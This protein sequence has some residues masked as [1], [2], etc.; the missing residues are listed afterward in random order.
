[1]RTSVELCGLGFQIGHTVLK[2]GRAIAKIDG[3]IPIAATRHRNSRGEH[4]EAPA[5]IVVRPAVFEALKVC[6]AHYS[7]IALMRALNDD[8]VAGVKVFSGMNKS[9]DRR[10]NNEGADLDCMGDLGVNPIAKRPLPAIS[11]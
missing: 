1:M 5:M 4:F 7:H 11:P 9:H 6:I 8:N 3:C 2:R 10:S